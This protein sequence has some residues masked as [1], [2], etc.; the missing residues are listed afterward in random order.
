[1]KGWVVAVGWVASALLLFSGEAALAQTIAYGPPVKSAI[2]D[3]GVDLASGGLGFTV[4]DLSIGVASAGGMTYTRRYYPHASGALAY[5]WVDSLGG[6]ISVFAPTYTVTIGL[7]SHSFTDTS[8]NQTSFASNEA[9][10]SVF[11]YNSSTQK[12]T[13]TG[14]DGSV[15]VF[16]YNIRHFVTT[17]PAPFGAITSLTKSDGTVYTYN[18]KSIVFGGQTAYRLESVVNNFG[19]QMHMFYGVNAQ[20]GSFS[21]FLSW[22]ALASVMAIN[23]AVDYCDPLAYTCTGLTMSWPTVTYAVP[24]DNA[25]ARTTTDA[26]SRTSRYTYGSVNQ[27]T[28]LRRASSATD[29]TTIGYDGSY[30]VTSVSNLAGT[31]TY[32]YSD[33]GS[34]RTVT[35][36]DPLS[37]TRVVTSDLS[38]GLVSTDTDGNGNTTTYAYDVYGR[39]SQITASEGNYTSYTYDT[40][41]NITQTNQV[42]KGAAGSVVTAAHYPSS[43]SNSVTCNKPTST[44]DPY[45][46]ETDYT[47]DP[48]HGGVLTATAPPAAAGAV[49]PQV[50]YSYTAMYAWYKTGAGVIVQAPSPVYRLTQTSQCQTTAS[51]AGTA[52]EAVSSIGYGT[53]SST[54]A[55]NLAPVTLSV[56]SGTGAL[57]ATTS[58]TYDPIGNLLTVD[59]PLSGTVDTVRY[60]YD[61]DRE[62]V[63]IVSPDPDDAGAL[64]FPALRYSYNADGQVTLVERGTV[65]SQSDSDWASMT[66][67]EQSA[68]AYDASGNLTKSSLV[69]G[70][71]AQTATQYSYDTAGNQ[72][73]V[74]VRMNPA[75]FAALPS[76]ACSLGT[77]GANGPDR[78]TKTTY[79][80]GNRVT[81]VTTSYATAAQSDYETLTYSGNGR[82]KTV[83]DALSNLT[84]FDYDWFDRIAKISYPVASQGSNTSSTTDYESYTYDSAIRLVGVRRRSGETIGFAYDDLGHVTEK[85]LPGGASSSVFYGYD[86]LGRQLYAHYGS[87]GGAGV[88]YSYDALSRLTSESAAGR[89]MAY[90]YDPAG[91]L[92]AITWPDALYV[93]YDHDLAGRVTAIRENGATSGVGVLASYSYDDLGRRTAIARAGGAGVSTSYS[94]YDGADRLTGFGHTF[95]AGSSAYNVAYGFSYN[96]AGQVIG[97]TST[98][99]LYTSHPGSQSKS[100]AANG[101]NQYTAVASVAFA[102]DSR[103]NLTSDGSRVFSYDVE[104]RLL[105]ASGPT[106]VSLAYDPLGRLQTSTAGGATTTFLYSGAALAAEFDAAGNLL[107]RYVPGPSGA[108]EPVVWYEG[109]GTTDRRWLEQDSQGSTIAYADSSGNVA[110]SSSV[111]GY[112]PNGEPS[113]WTGA[114]HRYTGQLMIPEAHL[115]SY[116][117]RAYDPFLGRFLQPD[118]AGD[119][120]DQNLYGYAADDPINLSD[121]SGMTIRCNARGT[122][123]HEDEEVVVNGQRI[124]SCPS[125]MTCA[126]GKGY[127]DNGP[128]LSSILDMSWAMGRGKSF[129]GDHTKPAHEPSVIINPLAAAIIR[130]LTEPG[131]HH[132]TMTG[133]SLCDADE[134]FKYWRAPFVS[135][136]G[137]RAG[138]APRQ[139]VELA[140][141]NWIEQTVDVRSRTIVNTTLP[142]HM[143]YYG[144]VTIHVSPTEAGSEVAVEGV[145]HNGNNARLN[146]ILGVPLFYASMVAANL[147][148]NKNQPSAANVVGGALY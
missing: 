61:A 88:D 90:Q 28:S 91:E 14:R 18:Y 50:R 17:N 100:Y 86:L 3:N 122:S 67:L 121:P 69:S 132:Y 68:S 13:Y 38:T 94:S 32:A 101:L 146:Y 26:L 147:E 85:D 1:M 65:N 107:R 27:I 40:R 114:R 46:R 78:I 83:L 109:A 133:G 74:A 52:D 81:K 136:P 82:V 75:I 142:G 119:A 73:C 47:Y 57:S 99:D 45:N 22:G 24:A 139:Q 129:P 20:P 112:G 134:Q 105:T 7:E 21:Q 138:S 104:N 8:G 9:D 125:D 39:V 117:A 42:G 71:A 4:T 49:R 41:G 113:G 110:S 95:A 143:F 25:S 12:Y 98:N 11:S 111:Y 84:T 59:G 115:Y 127:F 19:Y 64:K 140:L 5:G 131:S 93:S 56:G 126:G 96:A 102:Y 77:T 10:G 130:W 37:H 106:A 36:T 62:L 92:S 66:V 103:G 53:G 35:V 16:D 60:R 58:S 124:V 148:C 79:D 70:G 63:G 33:V 30:R 72:I 141:G 29:T 2:D 80:A 87:A 108:D 128:A 48:V 51:C 118:P 97:S 145:G 89:T 120:S 123:C 54:A 43:C 55:N 137:Y 76:S 31:W 44:Y 15:A 135:A 144:T 6:G 116:K 23:A 34:T